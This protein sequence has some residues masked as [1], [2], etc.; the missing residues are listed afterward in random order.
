MTALE[1]ETRT[2][3]QPPLPPRAITEVREG[4]GVRARLLLA[5]FGISGFAVLAAA[6]GI[7][8]FREVGERLGW[9]IRGFRRS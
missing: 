8:A 7:Y 1:A 3:R 6:A 9:S 2:F 5:L 4:L